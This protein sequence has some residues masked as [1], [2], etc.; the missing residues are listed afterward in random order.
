[1]SGGAALVESMPRAGSPQTQ[2][3]IFSDPLQKEN[4]LSFCPY[5]S[6]DGVFVFLYRIVFLKS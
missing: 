3:E 5:F 2:I 4:S 1:M 6:I